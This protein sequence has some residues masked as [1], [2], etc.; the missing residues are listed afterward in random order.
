M[1][2]VLFC[3]YKNTSEHDLVNCNIIQWDGIFSKIISSLL[4]YYSIY[5]KK[6]SL[7]NNKT[8]KISP[9]GVMQ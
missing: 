5:R 7:G 2:R 8:A 4:N 3:N 1:A 9:N 6:D